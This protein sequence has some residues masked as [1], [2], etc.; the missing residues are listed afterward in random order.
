MIS[1][2]WLA[3]RDRYERRIEGRVD[4]THSD[5]F[6]YTVRMLDNDTALELTA[7]CEGSPHYTIRSC[8]VVLLRGHVDA[9]ALENFSKLEGVRMVPG[10][11]RQLATSAGGRTGA[12]LLIAVGLEVARLARQVTRVPPEVTAQI[13]PGDARAVW[14]LDTASW[15][16]LPNSCF[17]YSGNAPELFDT[18]QVSSPIDVQ[19]IYSP[20]PGAIGVVSRLRVS[21]LVRTGMRLDL[22]QSMHDDFHGF[23]IH[24]Q[25]DLESG[26][27]L[28]ADSITS[29][30]P[31]RAVCDVPQKRIH[32]MVGQQLDTLLLRRRAQGLLG[33]SQGCSQLHDL[34]ADI[35]K[36][37]SA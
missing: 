23:D 36:L 18:L 5:A 6:T 26:V 24:Y 17:A 29:R 30:L 7:V 15:A 27:I 2:P 1:S 19:R 22:F 37:L 11:A 12:E 33:G 8:G 28:A 34:T 14:Q 35:F 4:N 9:I 20:R 13:A 10:Y 25:V 32:S 31:Y 21:R 3:D 16:D